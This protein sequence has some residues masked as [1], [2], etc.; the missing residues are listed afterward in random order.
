MYYNDLVLQP[1][2]S[3]ALGLCELLWLKILLA[4]RLM[5]NKPMKLYCDNKAAVDI[6]DKACRVY[7]QVGN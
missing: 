3:S 6:A 7:N 5:G 2:K 1:N 4:L